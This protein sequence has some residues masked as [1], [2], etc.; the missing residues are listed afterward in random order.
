MVAQGVVELRR[1]AAQFRQIVPGNGGEVVMLVV[2]SDIE[3]QTIDRPVIAEGLL[4]RINRV[5]LLDPARSNG[6]QPDGKEQ[7]KHEVTKTGR[8]EEVNDREI[9]GN[10]A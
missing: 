3:R 10:R 1:E 8:A 9:V 2:M 6:M 5:V 7:R 4:V